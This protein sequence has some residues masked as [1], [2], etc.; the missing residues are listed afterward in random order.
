MDFNT[1]SLK[2][3]GGLSFSL[4]RYWDGQVSQL[5]PILCCRSMLKTLQPVTYVCRS[6]DGSKE[7]FFI[8]FVCFSIDS[9]T[10]DFDHQLT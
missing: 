4:M 8:V 10:V 9:A 2:L 6:R 7:Y 5:L 3:P 1:L